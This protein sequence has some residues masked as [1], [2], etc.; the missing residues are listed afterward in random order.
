M[1]RNF[2]IVVKKIWQPYYKTGIPAL[3]EI[4]GGGLPKFSL[5]VICGPNKEILVR[6]IAKFI[7]PRV[8]CKVS[9]TTDRFENKAELIIDNSSDFYYNEFSIIGR[10]DYP[11]W[12]SNSYKYGKVEPDYI[13]F[14]NENYLVYIWNKQR[15]LGCIYLNL[16]NNKSVIQGRD[17]EVL[18][19]L[20]DF[21]KRPQGRIVD[22]TCNKRRMWKSLATKLHFAI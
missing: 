2:Q 16:I 5:T 21:Y 15:Y 14:L 1:L 4:L 7:K 6:Q 19:S 17:P 18:K 22:L 3:D 13:F 9:S 20:F 12:Q 8:A 11:T 10:S